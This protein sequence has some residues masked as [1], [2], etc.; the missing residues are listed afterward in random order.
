MSQKRMQPKYTVTGKA[1]H[2]TFVYTMEYYAATNNERSTGTGVD[3]D[4]P[5]DVR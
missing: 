5:H 1:K 2:K 4:Q 3:L